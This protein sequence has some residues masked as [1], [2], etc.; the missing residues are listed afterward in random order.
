MKHISHHQAA[1][2]LEE[3][4]I[5]QSSSF[6]FVSSCIT[7][8]L[9]PAVRNTVFINCPRVKRVL[10]AWWKGSHVAYDMNDDDLLTR[11]RFYFE[12]VTTDVNKLFTRPDFQFIVS[13]A[14]F[15]IMAIA[16]PNMPNA[17]GDSRL[18]IGD[19]GIHLYACY[20]C[21]QWC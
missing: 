15:L 20:V 6:R 1:W 5:S 4:Q 11:F 16:L 21:W 18:S 12:L 9:D 13:S 10:D 14:S 7:K 19:I 2:T 17:L 3:V 8:A